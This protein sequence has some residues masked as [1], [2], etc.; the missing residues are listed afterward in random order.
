MTQFSVKTILRLI[1][2]IAVQLTVIL[3]FKREEFQIFPDDTKI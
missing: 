3:T 2:I 1:K